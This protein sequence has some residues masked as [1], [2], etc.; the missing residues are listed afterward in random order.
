MKKILN[1]KFSFSLVCALFATLSMNADVINHDISSGCLII[2][3]NSNDDYVITGSTSNT[4][5]YIEVQFG[6]KGTITLS[7]CFFNFESSGYHS[8]IRICGKN[9]LS[10]TDPSRTN[11]NIILDGD[12]YIYNSGYGRAC[13][14]V[15]QGAQ[16]NI[17]AIEPCNNSSGTLTAIQMDTDG[18]AAIGSLNHYENTNETTATVLLSNGYTGT[19]AGGNVVISSGTITAKGGHG[20]GIGGGYDSYMTE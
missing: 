13:I 15:D 10:N 5:N 7:N 9:N 11:V 6:Y 20:A 18:G 16:I 3:G 14:Q 2:N 19:T 4:N 17:S 8:P 1:F 12:N